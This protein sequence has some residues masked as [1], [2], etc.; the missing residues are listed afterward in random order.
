MKCDLCKID[1]DFL[2]KYY[3]YN[4]DN[5]IMN[6]YCLICIGFFNYLNLY[7]PTFAKN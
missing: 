4:N 5:Y 1:Y 2:H 7:F 6:Y 3:S